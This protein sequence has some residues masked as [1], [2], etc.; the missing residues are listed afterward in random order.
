MGDLGCRNVLFAMDA[1]MFY[2]KALS[3]NRLMKLLLKIAENAQ[4]VTGNFHCYLWMLKLNRY[5]GVDKPGT[6]TKVSI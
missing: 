3:L 6:L 2:M 5:F 1:I 4:V